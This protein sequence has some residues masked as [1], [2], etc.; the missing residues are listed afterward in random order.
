[1]TEAGYKTLCRGY[2]M[3]GETP[4]AM[5]KRLARASSSSLG[6]F[7]LSRS[8][9]SKF[10][11]YMWKGWLCPASPVAANLGTSR[12]LPISCFGMSIPDSVEGIMSSIYEVAL[13]SKHGGGIGTYWGEVRPRNSIISSN[14][15][16]DGIVPFLKIL[17]AT[18]IGISQGG[19]RRGASSAYLPIEHDDFDEFIE[20]RRPQGDTNRQ[21]LNIHHGVTIGDDFMRKVEEGDEEARQRWTKLIKSRFETG[22][23]YLMFRDTAE[24]NRPEC[25]VKNDLHV[26]TSQLCSEIL[27]HT[28]EDHTFVCCLS[29][30]NLARWEEWKET[31]LPEVATYFLDGV[32][33]EFIEKAK[34]KSGF[35]R[36]VRF[37]EKSRAI[38]IGVIGFHTLLQ[39]KM[40]PFEGT[41]AH[42]L[43]S[44]I[45]KYIREGAERATALLASSL[46]EP[47]WCK[48]FGRR[49]THLMAVAPTVSNSTIAGGV[50]K[51]VEPIVANAYS[52]KTAKGTFFIKNRLLEDLLE[53][54][55]KSTPEV[56]RSIVLDEGSVQGLDFL[57]EEEKMV[58]L[59]ARE[60]NQYA[61]VRLAATRQR[62]IDQGQSINLFFP[63]NP[64]ARYL[65]QVHM[66]AWKQ[67]MSTLYY[68]RSSSVLRGDVGSRGHTR[69]ATD[70]VACE[71]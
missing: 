61:I 70:C 66:A 52:E 25:Y 5:Y 71:G 43:N 49:N 10:F 30:L 67:G 2:L 48:G 38:G 64:D 15:V 56:W 65:H 31:D 39:S 58:F 62:W 26:K 17:D 12:G 19:T 20:I 42:I 23:P 4:R 59:T 57:S 16:S 32:I 50:S 63:A 1:M 41:P 8:L 24:N 28:D 69:E 6:S 33:T 29:S 45:F 27:L 7:A 9:E 11:D 55:G 22:E 46:G 37:A 51:G 18:T 13:L 14:G 3:E 54:K 21:C 68:C 60:I 36:A 35:E 47:E 40:E 34:D 53:S 44:L